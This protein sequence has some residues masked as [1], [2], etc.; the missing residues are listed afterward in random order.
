[1]NYDD[2]NTKIYLNIAIKRPSGIPVFRIM[3]AGIPE[4]HFYLIT[5]PLFFKE[6]PMFYFHECFLL[7]YMPMQK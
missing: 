6:C 1:M 4:G 3:K 2:L 5:N 7:F